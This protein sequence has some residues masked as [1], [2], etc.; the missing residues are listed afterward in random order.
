MT[1]SSIVVQYHFRAQSKKCITELLS[2]V[3]M[4]TDEMFKIQMKSDVDMENTFEDEVD[5]GESILCM[6]IRRGTAR[7]M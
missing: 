6:P 1:L 7:R 2:P 5:Q 3:K 4:V